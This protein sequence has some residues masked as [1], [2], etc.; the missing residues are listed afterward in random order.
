M[1]APLKLLLF[2]PIL[3]GFKLFMAWLNEEG[4]PE[5]GPQETEKA[6]GSL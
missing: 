3:L 1:F 6:V 2:K 5:V 4:S